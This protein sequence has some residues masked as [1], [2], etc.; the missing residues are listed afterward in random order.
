MKLNILNILCIV[1]I[2]QAL[3]MAA[4]LL[5]SKKCD[6]QSNRILGFWLLSFTLLMSTSFL[7]SYGISQ[8]FMNYHKII[9]IISQSS[10]LIAPLFYFYTKS[11]LD[12]KFRFKKIDLVHL[13]PM[14]IATSYSTFK[15]VSIRNFI[16][17]KS[18][19]DFFCN[20]LFLAQNL[21]YFFLVLNLLKLYGVSLK[22]F[23]SY[24]KDLKYNWI[25]FLIIGLFVL[26]TA[27]LQSFTIKIVAKGSKWCTY[28][29]T[30]Y[31]MAL[32]LFVTT[33]IYLSLKRPIFFL[34]N[35]KYADSNLTEKDKEKLKNKLLKYMDDEKLY[36]DSN[37]NLEILAKKL[38]VLPKHLSQII[39]EMFNQK[40]NEFINQYRVK[41]CVKCL[42]DKSNGHKTLLRIAFECGFNTKATFNSAFKKFTGSTPKQF[43]KNL[44]KNKEFGIK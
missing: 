43:R 37:L 14:I 25:R 7:L 13:L 5:T 9:F 40:F 26:W 36:L 42:K 11:L 20:G 35:K 44:L 41:E 4:V 33:M 22:K 10:L 16:I 19:L 6:K 21:F 34:F 39:N 17:W 12:T 23:F 15:I 30:T 32:F 27:K 3:L 2:F 28:S 38:S 24:Q 8:Y 18:F 1:A 29:A 31:F